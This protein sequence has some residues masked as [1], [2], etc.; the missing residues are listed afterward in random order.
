MLN[1]NAGHVDIPSV[2]HLLRY[3]FP[4]APL[5]IVRLCIVSCSPLYFDLR[6]FAERLQ[7]RQLRTCRVSSSV[8]LREYNR[9]ECES[10]LK[11]NT[12]LSDL[13]LVGRTSRLESHRVSL[14]APAYVY[15]TDFPKTS[16]MGSVE[17]AHTTANCVKLKR[18]P[19]RRSV[20]LAFAVFDV[21]LASFF[22]LLQRRGQ[23]SSDGFPCTG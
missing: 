13:P 11:C 5:E 15:S 21:V 2:W 1:C 9:K 6:A 22:Y 20:D 7:G 8:S 14:V 18:L 3:S 16:W 12:G 10:E 23:V 19:R 17:S 4:F